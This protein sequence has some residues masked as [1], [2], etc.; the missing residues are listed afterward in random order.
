MNIEIIE[1]QEEYITIKIARSSQNKLFLETEEEIA[2]KVNE[3]G[4]ILTKDALEQI[5]EKEKVITING[6]EAVLKKENKK[7]T[8]PHTEV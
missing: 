3:I 2:Q 1:E 5:D 6:E 8:P 4:K 7:N